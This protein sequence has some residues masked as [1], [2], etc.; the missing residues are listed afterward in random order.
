VQ[1]PHEMGEEVESAGALGENQARGLGRFSLLLL[2]SIYLPD[3]IPAAI[4]PTI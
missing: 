1:L 3:G 2:F 4:I